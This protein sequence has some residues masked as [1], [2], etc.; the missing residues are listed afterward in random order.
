[1]LKLQFLSLTASSRRCY[2][3]V[4]YL[5]PKSL[6]CKIVRKSFC[7]I[8]G[9]L[10]IKIHLRQC[11]SPCIGVARIFSGGTFSSKSWWSF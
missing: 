8:R 2:M 6:A 3:D 5:S 11:L 7:H 9:C 1:M 10:A 4:A